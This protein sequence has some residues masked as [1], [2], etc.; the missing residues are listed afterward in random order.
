LHPVVGGVC[1]LLRNE[2]PGYIPGYLR[3]KVAVHTQS[4]DGRI[5]GVSQEQDAGLSVIR[6]QSIGGRSG[7]HETKQDEER[8]DEGRHREGTPRCDGSISTRGNPAAWAANLTFWGRIVAE[9]GNTTGM[10]QERTSLADFEHP[11]R[12]AFPT[13]LARCPLLPPDLITVEVRGE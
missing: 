11:A 6:L 9:K 12:F 4:F 1:K 7:K 13:D 10:R 2:Y 5:L 3:T 8:A